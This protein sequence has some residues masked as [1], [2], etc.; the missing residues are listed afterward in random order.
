LA[1]S[2]CCAVSHELVPSLVAEILG[3]G[4]RT[5]KLKNFGFI[6]GLDGGVILSQQVGLILHQA[7]VKQPQTFA[8]FATHG[9]RVYQEARVRGALG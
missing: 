1:V 6:S 7:K 9:L 3:P 5:I 2:V 4:E 8:F